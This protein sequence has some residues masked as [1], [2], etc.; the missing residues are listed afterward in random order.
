MPSARIASELK[1]HLYDVRD[2]AA[3][4]SAECPDRRTLPAHVKNRSCRPQ[5]PALD[6]IRESAPF[7]AI[8]QLM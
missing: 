4:I 1:A 5:P 3:L 2:V 8:A 6:N 7:E